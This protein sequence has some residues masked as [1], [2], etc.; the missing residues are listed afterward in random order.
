MTVAAATCTR[1]EV[2][3]KTARILGLDA[4]ADLLTALGLPALFVLD[5]GVRR[6]TGGWPLPAEERPSPASVAQPV[7]SQPA[8]LPRQSSGPDPVYRSVVL[9][10]RAL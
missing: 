5:D 1:A 7:A 4:G 9:T 3:A 2:A 6:A 10:V 8:A